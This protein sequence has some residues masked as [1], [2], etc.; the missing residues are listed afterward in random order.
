MTDVPGRFLITGGGGFLGSHLA[1][2]LASDGAHVSLLVRPGAD[3]RRL[4]DVR[5]AFHTIEGDVTDYA[6]LLHACRQA[7]PTTIFHLAANTA[8]RRFDG[9]WRQV[10]ASLAVN[11]HGTLNLLRA[12]AESGAPLA[13]F[14]RT[15]GLEEYGDGT[16]PSDEAQ[17]EQPGSPYSASQV[18]ATHWCR[19]LQSHLRFA[20]TTLRPAL[21]YGPAQD[22]SF[23]IPALITALLRG[24]RF[25]TS[26]GTQV[27][28]LVYVADAVR[29]LRLAAQPPALRG[30]V[31]NVASGNGYRVRDVV[32]L[33]ARQLG[34]PDLLDIGAVTARGSEGRDVWGRNDSARA[35]LG[36]N[37]DTD[38]ETGLARTIA[39]YREQVR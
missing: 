24:E 25:A 31:I 13:S 28:D 1:R 32:E 29:A 38:L 27:R 15:G 2:A 33:I 26:E 9:D 36:W 20:V 12:A 23:L 30:A 37:A 3:L 19:M 17:R 39:W 7:M 11:F 5:D 35:L 14:V 18:A 22:T 10:D 4:E 16:T 6:S 34:R 8:V 21:L